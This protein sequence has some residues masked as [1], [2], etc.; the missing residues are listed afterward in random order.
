MSFQLHEWDI[1]AL[2]FATAGTRVTKIRLR[3]LQCSAAAARAAKVAAKAAKAARASK[4]ARAAKP[5][6][7][8]PIRPPGHAPP[9]QGPIA[10][11]S[12]PRRTVPGPANGEEAI[13]DLRSSGRPVTS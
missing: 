7:E 3:S 6:P 4:A 9:R 11:S 12:K 13:W 8:H 1:H 10:C 5:D 2:C